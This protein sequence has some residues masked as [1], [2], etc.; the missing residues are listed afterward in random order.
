[1]NREKIKKKKTTITPLVERSITAVTGQTRKRQVILPSVYKSK[2]LDTDYLRA[3]KVIDQ[4][5]GQKEIISANPKKNVRRSNP[6]NKSHDPQ[7]SYQ[8]SSTLTPVG[9]Q[10]MMKTY[11]D[12][13]ITHLTDVYSSKRIGNV[14]PRLQTAAYRHRLS[15]VNNKNNNQT[16]VDNI[17]QA[18]NLIDHILH[19]NRSKDK[20]LCDYVKWQ[21]RWTQNC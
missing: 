19:N 18:Q 17:H 11:E 2:E 14:L 7:A 6:M 1:M 15:P 5:N 21:H 12:T 16:H 20:I 3:L 4:T 13:L 9:Q 8:F 10:A